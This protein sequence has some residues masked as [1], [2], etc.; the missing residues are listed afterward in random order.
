MFLTLNE[1]LEMIKLSDEGMLEAK[2]GQKLGLLCQTVSQ[3]VNIQEKLVRKIQ[4]SSPVNTQVIRK[5]NRLIIIDMEKTVV[6][7][8]GDQTSHNIPLSKV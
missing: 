7:W 8:T 6:I 4:S 1:K 2:I 5:W 3:A